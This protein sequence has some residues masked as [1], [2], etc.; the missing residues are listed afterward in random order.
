[1]RQPRFQPPFDEWL[2]FREAEEMQ[3]LKYR[4]WRWG[5]SFS[6]LNATL[7]SGPAISKLLKQL[8]YHYRVGF[9][10]EMDR[11]DNVIERVLTEQSSM[12]DE[13][14]SLRGGLDW[15]QK[16]I[17][18]FYFKSHVDAVLFKLLWD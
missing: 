14:T 13:W 8:G 3:R 1:M 9:P 2:S 12:A 10:H 18:H 17:V 11:I 16:P 7:N 4:T 5:E 15:Q 6:V